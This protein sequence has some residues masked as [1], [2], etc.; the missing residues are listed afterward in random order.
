MKNT[1]EA[2]FR[3]RLIKY[4]KQHGVTKAAIRYHLS[5]KTVH[6]WLKRYDGTLASL[7]DRSRRPHSS[8]KAHTEEE[9]T[10]IVRRLDRHGWRDLIAV[11]Q[12]LVERDGYTRSYGGFKLYVGR[13]RKAP[14]EKRNKRK[15]K[16]YA[17]AEF[18]G[19]KVQIDVK[20]V[21]SEC[22]VNGQKYYVF[23]AVDEYSRWAY[24]YMY[25]EISTYSAQDFL[26]R[27]LNA[28]PYK[29]KRI[30]TDNGAEFTKQL[31][32]NDPNDLT[33]FEQKLKDEGI[34]YQRIRV[35]TPRH[36]G[37]VERQNGIDGTRFYDKLK[38]YCLEDG[39]KQLAA[40]QRKSNTY[41]KTCLDMRS[42]NE[43]LASFDA[44]QKT[45]Q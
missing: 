5:R 4:A 24:R 25:E 7:E 8:P 2:H 32:V 30:Q 12:E 22:I 38:I 36:N 37:K 29:V 16:P 26:K 41:W 33:L 3:Q 1:T 10:K 35:A 43:V 42:P 20:H 9:R 6:K 27:F 40:Y 23:V 31:K 14:P 17:R 34:E 18:P 21:P 45:K 39:Q 15:N 13:L 44:E 28:F 19:Q 11:Y